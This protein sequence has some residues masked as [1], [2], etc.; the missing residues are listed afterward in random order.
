MI[1]FHQESVEQSPR[2][3]GSLDKAMSVA[4]L[5]YQDTQ[6]GQ[7]AAPAETKSGSHR[8][9]YGAHPPMNPP[10]SGFRYVPSTTALQCLSSVWGARVRVW[11]FG[12]HCRKP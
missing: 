8:C 6:W 3:P 2:S 11:G 4:G 1:M 7:N 9:I 5:K 10:F 12:E